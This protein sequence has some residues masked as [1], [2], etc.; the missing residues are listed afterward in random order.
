M[1]SSFC[2]GFAATF[3][4]L[5]Q[6]SVIERALNKF[7]KDCFPLTTCSLPWG[8]TLDMSAP[9]CWKIAP[10][11]LHR[12]FLHQQNEIWHMNFFCGIQR[13]LYIEGIIILCQVWCFLFKNMPIRKMS[14]KLNIEQT[15]R[16]TIFLSL[17]L[18]IFWLR[19]NG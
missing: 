18:R 14:L 9:P 12:S 6:Y 3:I 19:H 16:H 1:L 2:P 10:P 11:H 8:M 17:S 13:P 5:K 4:C 15:Q 7:S